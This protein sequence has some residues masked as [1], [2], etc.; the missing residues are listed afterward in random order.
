MMAFYHL[1]IDMVLSRHLFIP[2]VYLNLYRLGDYVM[3]LILR[4][5]G[6]F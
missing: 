2:M 6:E 3:P 4:Q 1:Q 5:R